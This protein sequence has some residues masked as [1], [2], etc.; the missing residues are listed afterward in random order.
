MTHTWLNP[1]SPPAC[2]D[3][4]PTKSLSPKA[5][6]KDSVKT[7]PKTKKKEKVKRKD[8]ARQKQQSAEKDA[9]REARRVE[10]E[11][12]TAMLPQ[13]SGHPTYGLIYLI[14]SDLL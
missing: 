6:R 14:Y 5:E 2:D 7:R 13:G 8:E 12:R 1:G 9:V 10:R 11:V 4:L 3:G